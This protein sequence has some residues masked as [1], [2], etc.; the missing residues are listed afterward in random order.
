[1]EL[2]FFGLLLVG[3]VA[4][5]VALL[6]LNRRL[7]TAVRASLSGT[8]KL[9]S[10]L[11]ESNKALAARVTAAE[12][13]ASELLSVNRNV[14]AS[15]GSVSAESVKAEVEFLRSSNAHLQ[16]VLCAS[17]DIAQR[18]ILELASPAAAE[19]E[20]RA[21][22]GRDYQ[23]PFKDGFSAMPPESSPVDTL[24]IPSADRENPRSRTIEPLP[25]PIPT[26][27]GEAAFFGALQPSPSALFEGLE[28]DVDAA[29]RP[30]QS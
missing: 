30:P 24:R 4:C 14:I 12:E 27:G 6:V 11:L 3:T 22:L 9:R 13:Q 23:P 7:T 2:L 25:P 8:E 19:G 29:F 18:R 5:P 17:A 10:Q 20:R 21:A 1:M 28:D 16:N 15:L 26:A